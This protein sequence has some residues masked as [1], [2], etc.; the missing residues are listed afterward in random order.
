MKRM[1]EYNLNKDIS[2]KEIDG[3][4][5]VNGWFKFEG[6]NKSENNCI[7][8]KTWYCAVQKKGKEQRQEEITN[9]IPTVRD[10]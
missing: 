1:K 10:L 9:N 7:D 8:Y 4:Y 5:E 2:E 6:K 3:G